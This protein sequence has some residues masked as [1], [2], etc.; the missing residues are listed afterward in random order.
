MKTLHLEQLKKYTV[1]G[2]EKEWSEALC[3]NKGI[4]SIKR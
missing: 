2:S 4:I 3:K 1:K